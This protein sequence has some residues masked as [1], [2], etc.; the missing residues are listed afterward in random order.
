MRRPY[1]VRSHQFWDQARIAYLAGEPASSVCGRFG[2]GLSAFRKRAKAQGWRRQ[3]QPDDSPGC[4]PSNR[5]S[6]RRSPMA[7][8][9]KMAKQAALEAIQQDRVA[10]TQAWLEAI[11]HLEIQLEWTL[12]KAR[13]EAQARALDRALSQPRALR[14]QSAQVDANPRIPPYGLHHADAPQSAQSPA[15]IASARSERIPL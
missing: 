2:L 4:A 5:L 15:V 9:L 6:P 13:I 14:Q 11:D 1:T 12:S 3:D 10:E 8:L 7:Q